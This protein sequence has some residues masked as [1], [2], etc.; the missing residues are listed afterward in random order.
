MHALTAQKLPV[1]VFSRLVEALPQ[2]VPRAASAYA[3][4]G[5]G[6]GAGAAA[7]D[8]DVDPTERLAFARTYAETVFS[9]LSENVTLATSRTY[10][11]AGPEVRVCVE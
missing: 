5:A 2:H 11:L 9:L 8:D 10:L 6:A 1:D 3:A 4:A 7:D